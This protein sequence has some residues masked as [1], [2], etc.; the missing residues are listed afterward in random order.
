MGELDFISEFPSI[1]ARFNISPETVNCGCCP[2]A[3]RIP[4]LGY[5]IC[6]RRR[7]I[8]SRV[9]ERLIQKRQEY[10]RQMAGAIPEGRDRP[11]C[12]SE[13]AT[14]LALNAFETVR[15]P[16]SSRGCGTPQDDSSRDLNCPT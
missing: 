12:H 11:S 4:E 15:D 1:M 8:N 7:G 9:V 3:P 13:R 6:Q 2:E 14:N 16:S 5:R 10:K